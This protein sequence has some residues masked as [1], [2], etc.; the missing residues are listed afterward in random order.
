MCVYVCV[1]A[2]RCVCVCV[3]VCVRVC[4]CV[5]AHTHVCVH[6]CVSACVWAICLHFTVIFAVPVV[7]TCSLHYSE[8]TQLRTLYSFSSVFHIPHFRR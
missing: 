3:C 8:L 2:C 4:V 7:P 1:G 6:A 5:C